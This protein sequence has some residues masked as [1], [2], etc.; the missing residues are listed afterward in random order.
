[1]VTTQSS[2]LDYLSAFAI[3]FAAGVLS[4][5]AFG[6]YVDKC[7]RDAVEDAGNTPA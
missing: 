2:P 3:A 5:V 4:T 7:K 1:M 6:A